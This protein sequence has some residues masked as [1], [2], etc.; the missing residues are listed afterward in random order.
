MSLDQDHRLE[1]VF[2]AARDLPPPER[3][4]F[5]DGACGALQDCTGKPI[6]CLPRTN[7][8]RSLPNIGQKCGNV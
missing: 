3:T 5:P 4:V 8:A 2:S 7:K 6:R 1:E